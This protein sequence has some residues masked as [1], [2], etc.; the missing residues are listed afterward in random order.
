M[1]FYDPSAI[2]KRLERVYNS[3]D[4]FRLHIENKP[5]TPIK[6]AL[7]KPKEQELLQNFTQILVQKKRLETSGYP[8]EYKVFHFKKMGQQKLP[9]A[10]VIDDLELFL[11]LLKCQEEYALFVRWYA[12]LW[13]HYPKLKTLFLRKPKLVVE[14]AK[15]WEKLVLIVDFFLKHV[16]P[17]IYIREISLQ[18]IDSKY[19]QKHLKIV[20]LLLS[21]LLE[22]EP[23][24]T[25]KD[26]AFEKCYK[27]K[28]ILPQVRFRILDERLHLFGCDDI[29]LPINQFEKLKLN[30]QKVFVVEN[31]IT[32]LSFP[33]LQGAI[34]IFGSGYNL[35]ILKNTHWLDEKEIYYWGDIDMDG[36]AILS[37]MRS[38]FSQTKSFLMDS[39]TLEKWCDRS[40]SYSGSKE[41][42]LKH[43][44]NEESILYQRLASNYYG[45]NFRLEQEMI[46]FDYIREIID[47][48]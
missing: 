39:K 47:N 34:V 22:K 36:F 37:Q 17:N 30:C 42:K 33:P 28:Y 40:V 43:L 18:G 25:L 5:F 10:V 24:T 16:R 26:F 35:G 45:K 29:T 27:L 23:L 48:L 6:V 19:I 3:G 8:L 9:V 2:Q 1:L 44:T 15:E 41:L 7:K 31:K 12:Y 38:Y 21:C 11:S 20:D 4:I 13:K 14:Y 32:F 46:P